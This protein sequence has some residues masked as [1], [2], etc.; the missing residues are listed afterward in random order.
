MPSVVHALLKAKRRGVDV[1]VIVDEKNNLKESRSKAP[2]QA[3]NLL[4]NAGIPTRTVQVYSIHHDKY[5]VVDG[6]HVETGSFNYSNAAA[7]R[8]SENV[9][10]LWNHPE[11]ASK[12]LAH[13][14][15]RWDR[16]TPYQSTY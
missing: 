6:K 2:Q 12:Y 14:R 1:A 9:L 8:N 3:L 10:A 4:V 7:Q 16:G 5:I 11:L 15:D 13:W